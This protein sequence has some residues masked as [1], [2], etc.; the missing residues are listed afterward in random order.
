MGSTRSSDC[1]SQMTAK[2]RLADTHNWKLE[3]MDL[4]G[5]PVAHVMGCVL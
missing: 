5:C 1:F 3:V 4:N 2:R